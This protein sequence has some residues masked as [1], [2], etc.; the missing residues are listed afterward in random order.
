MI[1][2]FKIFENNEPK[3]KVGDTVYIKS[4]YGKEFLLDDDGSLMKCKI[5]EVRKRKT[6]NEYKLDGYPFVTFD[7]DDLKSE[8]EMDAEKY[9]L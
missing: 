2:K 8:Y 1:T 6:S 9:N 4:Y 3:F 7:D 5:K